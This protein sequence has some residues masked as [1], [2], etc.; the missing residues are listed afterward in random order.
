LRRLHLQGL[1][2]RRLFSDR[3]S[4]CLLAL[5]GT[6]WYCRAGSF[7]KE[8]A[9][10][11]ARWIYGR[12]VPHI[13]AGFIYHRQARAAGQAAAAAAAARGSCVQK[14]QLHAACCCSLL[15]AAMLL[16]HPTMLLLPVRPALRLPAA[17]CL[18]WSW[19]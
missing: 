9:P 13:T 5:H 1:W 4:S 17:A 6:A 14:R 15:A 16:T 12:G 19:R 3:V 2:L 7:R 11:A 10:F 8:M 18:R